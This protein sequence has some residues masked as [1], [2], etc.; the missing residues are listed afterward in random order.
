MAQT[1]G[2]GDLQ[3]QGQDAEQQDQLKDQQSTDIGS[4]NP[5]VGTPSTSTGG[6]PGDQYKPAAFSQRGQ[7]TGYTNIQKI[8]QANQPQQLQQAV[9]GNVQ[10]QVQQGAGNIGQAQQQF[11]QQTAANQANT[12]ANQ[13]LVQNVL[14]NP[15]QYSNAPANSPNVL[16]TP[17]GAT[18]STPVNTNVYGTNTPIGQQGSLFTKLISGQYGGP[19]GLVN[20]DQLQAQ[21]Q[22][23]AQMGQG[24]GTPGGRTAIL[25]NVV[26]KPQYSKGQQQ[27]DALL[28]GQGNTQALTQ[29]RRQA[30]GVQDVLAQQAAGASEQAKEQTNKAQ[31]FGKGI[32]EQLGQ[33]VSTADTAL[34]QQATEAQAARDAQYQKMLSDLKSGNINQQEAE[35]LGLTSGQN[36]YNVL[37]DPSKFLTESNLKANAQNIA[38]GQDYAKMRALQQLAGTYSPQATQDIFRQYNDPTQA[39]KFTADTAITGDKTALQEALGATNKDY[40]TRLAPAQTSVDQSE[41]MLRLFL[42]RFSPEDIAQAKAEGIDVHNLMA[43]H[44]SGALGGS[45][46]QAFQWILSNRDTAKK[47]L[48]ATQQQLQQAYGTPMTVNVVPNE[49]VGQQQPIIRDLDM[50]KTPKV[51]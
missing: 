33:S 12:T 40:Q 2:F 32:Q 13:E 15:I 49:Q 3:N 29:A 26:G 6:K 7:G 44:Y 10:Q 37:N 30:L 18:T 4:N 51:S 34:Q 23:L 43:K 8:V 39:G 35:M 5:N 47:N 11:A 17:G 45:P 27:L 1:I 50:E 36:V 42:G 24:L 19:T 46:T 38:G 21:A 48:A 16:G 14:N 31:A 28:L 20:Q 22:A 25:Q 41:Q 9:V